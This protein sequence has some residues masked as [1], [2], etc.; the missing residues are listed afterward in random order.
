MNDLRFAIRQL[1][2][3]PGFAALAVLTLALGIGA[4]STVF[5]LI[6]G[7]LLTP[8]PFPQPEQLMLITSSRQDGQPYTRGLPAAQWTEWQKDSKTFE[9]IAA[10]GWTFN[11]LVLPDGSQS[12]EGMRVTPEY[13]KVIGSK[14]LLGRV[15][16][17]S[18][19]QGNRTTTVI[20]GH[21]LWQKRFNGDPA[22]IGQTI[23]ISRSSQRQTVVGV[24]PPG[25]RFL[26]SPNV[27]QEPN[28]NENAQVDYWLPARIPPEELKRAYTFL[29]GRLRADATPAAA[30]AEISSMAARQA[31]ADPDF[32]GVNVHVESLERHMNREGRRLL[33]PMAGAVGLVFLIACGNAAGLLLARG[34]SRQHEY[35]VRSALG[36]G[37]FQL[38]KPVLAE[39]L[40]LS[41]CGG[42]LG[43]VFSLWSVD[44]LKVVA[45]AGIPRLDSVRVG[46]PLF[47]FCL[48]ASLIAGT[49]AGF[50]P[51]LRSLARD[52]AKELKA[53]GRTASIGGPERR[54][55]GR[56]AAAQVALT[57][58]LLVGA[59]LLIQTVRSLAH[60]RPGYDIENILTMSV[61]TVGTN[62]QNFHQE[63]VGRVGRL[64]GVKATAFVWGVPLT[65]NK[66]ENTF[67]IEGQPE[68]RSENNRPVI[69][70]RSVTQ[71]YFTLIGLTLTEGRAFR[72][73][74]DQQSPRVAIVNRAF[75]DKYFPGRS[76]IG[77]TFWFPGDRKNPFE[78]TGVLADT[79]TDSLTRQAEPEVYVSFWQMGAFS[80]HLA[81]RTAGDPNLMG[82]AV[83]RELR[84]IDP[85]VS[86]EN[87]RTLA[88]IRAESVASRTFAMNLLVG[89]AVIAC[90]LA[91]VGIYGVL[92]LAVG[93]RQTEIA[94][95]MAIGAQRQDVL[96]LMLGDGVR[97]ASLGIGVGI[98]I[99]LGLA[100]GLK[101]YLFEVTPADP[102]TL[103]FMVV[104]VM[105][106]TL[107]TCWIP[108]RRASRVD[109]LVA[110][111]SE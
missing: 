99:A 47:V 23:Q 48:G 89:F 97:M 101:T 24:M 46:W 28:Y 7:V 51:A 60:V 91:A 100:M 31:G 36:A 61:T 22:I 105:A 82:A 92:S 29:V 2:R 43:I 30:Q 71:D 76:G 26:P 81:V 70:T 67:E 44:V 17:D 80:K 94:I 55:L 110:L 96:N 35:A 21:D 53:G 4:T 104:A 52:P 39:S 107:V 38:C 84:A 65:G 66:W 37:S 5:S 50:L 18:D 45:G 15:F 88:D 108:A 68:V 90:L 75:V 59:G 109:P 13:F 25:I 102:L 6:Q 11:F 56:V 63:A 111:R 106:L 72:A 69:G 77:K 57:L 62:Y 85:T 33:L 19:V 95:R 74:D 1:L 93:S 41:L 83:Q 14:P 78:I 3:S 34:L 8:P 12:M 9:A 10:Y 73:S 98:V 16:D 64:P 27:A 87:I 49:I 40:V 58:A 42:A 20:L 54:L 103:G 79:R 32:A 86:V